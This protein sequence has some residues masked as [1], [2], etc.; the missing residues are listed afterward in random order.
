MHLR[1]K[2]YSLQHPPKKETLSSD[3]L[4]QGLATGCSTGVVIHWLLCHSASYIRGHY[5]ISQ[6]IAGSATL[7]TI[8]LSFKLRSTGSRSL[9]TSRQYF[10]THHI[11]RWCWKILVQCT[12]VSIGFLLTTLTEGAGNIFLCLQTDVT[13]N[14]HTVHQ[15]SSFIR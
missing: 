1:R 15:T 11:S 7:A 9:Y 4:W 12:A 5:Y 3:S 14:K 6:L 13:S 8:P 2:H 10:F